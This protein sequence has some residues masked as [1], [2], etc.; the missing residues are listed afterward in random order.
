MWH[1]LGL[2]ALISGTAAASSAAP[3][4]IAPQLYL[5]EGNFNPGQQ[6]DGNTLI[7]RGEHGLVVL[8]TGRHRAH[9]QAI[10]DFADASQLPIEAIVNSHWHLDHVGGNIL[11]RA[12]FPEAHVYASNGM[13]HALTRFLAKYKTSLQGLLDDPATDAADKDAYTKELAL[14]Q[15][16]QALRPTDVVTTAQTA[17]LGG[18]TLQFGVEAHAATSADLWILDTARSVLASGD[19]V[20]LPVPFLDTAC[21]AQWQQALN[22]LAAVD[23]TRLVPGHGAIMTKPQFLIYKTAF[24]H[25]LTCAAD[26]Q[27]NDACI[28][29]WLHDTRDFLPSTD[30]QQTRDALT[31]YLEYPLKPENAERYCNE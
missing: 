2:L 25:L 12:S 22:R 24:D 18:Q 20:T 6:P 23:F 16:P 26:R 30:T 17:Q 5:L 31:F 1:I 27:G 13:E 9:T 21:P 11:L 10:L 19:L 3:V 15:H 4:E 14:L 8:D 7:W 29:G 28:A